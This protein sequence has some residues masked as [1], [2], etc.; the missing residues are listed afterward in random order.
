MKKTLSFLFSLIMVFSAISTLDTSFAEISASSVVKVA[1]V[2]DSITYG[3]GHNDARSY[4]SVLGELL[5]EEYEVKNFGQGGQTLMKK[6]DAPYW[7]SG[8]YK[9]SKEYNPDIVIIMLGTN[10]GKHFNWVTGIKETFEDDMKAIIDVYRNLPSKPDVYFMTSPTA[11]N[12]GGA[13]IVPANVEEI[14]SLQRKVASEVSCPLIDMNAF[15]KDKE[16]NFPDNIHPDAEGYAYMADII[17]DV[18]LRGTTLPAPPVNITCRNTNKRAILLWDDSS[19]GGSY[20]KYYNVYLDGEF[21][22]S[23]QTRM[24]NISDLVNGKTYEIQITAVNSTGESEHSEVIEC[25]PTATVPKV[26]GVTDG[27]EYD[28]ADGTVSITWSTEATATLNGVEISKGVEITNSGEYTLVVTNDNVVVT[29]EFIIKDGRVTP[30]D[31]DKDGE[32]TVA[33]ALAILRVAAKLTTSQEAQFDIMDMDKD[34]EITVAD[35]L[36]VLRIAAKMD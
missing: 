5:G 35:A 13:Y 33:D 7:N 8:V 23:V 12:D 15:T 29:V 22:S 19:Y 36:A 11:F 17:S 16:K 21:H 18:I 9:S 25:T 4:P 30:G 26:T 2:G 34:G 20:N 14:A 27:G 24:A 31:P 6:A 28:L 1:C 32:I 3:F 10:D